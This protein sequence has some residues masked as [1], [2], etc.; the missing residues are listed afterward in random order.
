ML[1][2]MGHPV[3]QSLADAA[4]SNRVDVSMLSESAKETCM[5]F[6][7]ILPFWIPLFA[8]TGQ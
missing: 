5:E 6:I 7:S 8:Q 4:S 2:V 3:T 1:G